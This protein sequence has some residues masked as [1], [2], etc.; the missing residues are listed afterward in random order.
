MKKNP[1]NFMTVFR[2]LCKLPNP[3][4]IHNKKWN[5]LNLKQFHGKTWSFVKNTYFIICVHSKIV[6]TIIILILN[7][8]F[9]C[10]HSKIIKGVLGQG[11]RFSAPKTFEKVYSSF[12]V[13]NMSACVIVQFLVLHNH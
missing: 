11:F 2:E 6:Q 8:F 9:T 10:F 3:F 1:T 4:S 7:Y 5:V 12:W 13:K